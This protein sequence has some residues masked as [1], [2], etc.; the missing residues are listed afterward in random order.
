MESGALG[1][2]LLDAQAG[3]VVDVELVALGLDALG[4]LADVGHLLQAAR[5]IAAA[6]VGGG[7]TWDFAGHHA[8]HE[9][10]GGHFEA[11]NGGAVVVVEGR[12]G[13]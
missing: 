1:A 11:K 6:Q 5:H 7:V 8:L 4:L 10:Q 3:G 2:Q 9:L 12:A 13:Q